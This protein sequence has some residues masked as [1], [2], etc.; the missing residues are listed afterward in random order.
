MSQSNLSIGKKIEKIRKLKGVKQETLANLLGISAQAV[1]K[2]EQSEHIDDA[3]L[4]KIA[5]ALEIS[6]E[7]IK[8]FDMETSLQN[9]FNAECSGFN[10][11]C[12]F[13]PLDKIVELYEALLRSERD[14][15]RLFEQM[16]A[17]K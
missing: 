5:Q 11:N 4:G 6:P 15:L 12:T 16:M 14:K 17:K 13:N 2:M 9:V 7:V 10:Y 8:S 3:R 1:S